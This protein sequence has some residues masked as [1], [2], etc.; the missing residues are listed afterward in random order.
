MIYTVKC[1]EIENSLRSVTF[2]IGLMEIRFN[3]MSQRIRP[4]GFQCF[5]QV[6]NLSVLVIVFIYI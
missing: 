4:Y 6:I 2:N 5:L 3:K 1:L